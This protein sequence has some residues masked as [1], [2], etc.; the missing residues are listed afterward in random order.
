MSN[1]TAARHDAAEA[2]VCEVNVVPTYAGMDGEVIDALLALLDERVAIDF[3]REVLCL[4]VHLLQGL[5]DRNRAD[6]N[7]T[8]AYDPFARLVDVVAGREVHQCIATPLARPDCLLHLFVDA[9]CCGRVA[10]VC[11]YLNEE[12]ATDNHRFALWMVDVGRQHSTASC[13]LVAD[14]FGRDVALD[15]QGLAVHVLANADVLHLGRY[16]ASLGVCH[17]SDRLA[18][19]GLSWQLD[20]L[21]TKCVERVVGKA[22]PAILATYLGELLCIRSQIC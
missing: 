11:V 1:G 5:I 20:V 16:D 15:A 8:I 7:R 12:I 3:P 17:L 18:F 19:Q 9:G 2:I 21:E 4:A 14:E 22:H 13:Y 10:D 6:G